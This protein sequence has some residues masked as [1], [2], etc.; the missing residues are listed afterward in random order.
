MVLLASSEEILL[1]A[2]RGWLVSETK[3]VR[4]TSKYETKHQNKQNQSTVAFD[5]V[6]YANLSRHLMRHRY[7]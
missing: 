2:L 7:A 3:Y 5:D 1:E 6:S 4:G